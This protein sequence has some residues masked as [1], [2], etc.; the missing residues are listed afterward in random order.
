MNSRARVLLVLAMLFAIPLFG[1]QTNA[2]VFG[3]VT[4]AGGGTW[5]QGS[6]AAYGDPGPQGLLR[7]TVQIPEVRAVMGWMDV[8]Y[9]HFSSETQPVDLE[10][11]GR[12]FP[13]DQSTSQDCLAFHLGVQ[14][15]N[16]TR[17]GFFRPRA[18]IGLGA[19]FF[20]T[21][22]SLKEVR[23]GGE[24]EDV[25]DS[26]VTDSQELLGWRGQIG[27]DFFFTPRWGISFDLLYDHIWNLNRKDGDTNVRRTSRYQGFAI[28]VVIPFETMAQ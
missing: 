1:A 17:R 23:I 27:S 5:P 26:D 2:A 12:V 25:F 8:N 15:G 20:F 16:H 4:L 28:G 6:F 14:A 11:L 24:D 21:N 13:A 10:Y 22:V 19:Y 3:D 9:T 7:V 18:G